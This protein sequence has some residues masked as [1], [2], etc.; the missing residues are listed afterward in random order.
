MGPAVFDTKHEAQE[1]LK[2]Y[3]S[4]ML[5][6][7]TSINNTTNSNNEGSSSNYQKQQNQKRRGEKSNS[8]NNKKNYDKRRKPGRRPSSSSSST[9]REGIKLKVFEESTLPPINIPSLFHGSN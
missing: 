8:N 9:R 4:K 2:Q 5:V 3:E 6:R 1:Y 7:L